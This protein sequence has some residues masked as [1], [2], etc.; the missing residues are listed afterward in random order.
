MPDAEPQSAPEPGAGSAHD[1]EPGARSAP[2]PGAAPGAGPA[3][4]EWPAALVLVGALGSL[5]VV[6]TG[7]FRLGS[8]LL[9]AT[10]VLALFLRLFLREDEAGLLAVRSKVVDVVTL[11]VLGVGLALLAFLVPPPPG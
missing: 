8:V 10:I 4:R 7:S 11:L 1:A 2:E 5:V 6:A 3:A 9:A